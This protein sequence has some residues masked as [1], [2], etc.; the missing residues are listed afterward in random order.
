MKYP[1]NDIYP[2]IQGEGCNTGVPMVMVRLQGCEVGCP[3]CDTKETWGL[4]SPFVQRAT[5]EDAMGPNRNYALAE[6]AEIAS[7]ARFR[8]QKLHW[9][10]LS[11]GEPAKYSLE[12]LVAALHGVG[13]RVAIETSGTENGHY[14]SRVD[15][16]TLSPKF[17]MPGG[18]PVTYWLNDELKFPIGKQED[19]TRLR[20]LIESGRIEQDAVICLQPVSLSKAATDLCV[21]ACYEHGWRLSCQTQ[22]FL[23][24]P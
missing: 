5:L 6:P 22:K 14:S 8:G 21:R 16:I 18:K 17:D 15:W 10:L 12:D 19:L 20:G 23:Q 3:W 1:V 7:F 2:C 13:F 24:L 9:A 11:G 4:E